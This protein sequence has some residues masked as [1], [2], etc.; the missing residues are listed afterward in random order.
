M[1][2]RAICIALVSCL[3]LAATSSSESLFVLTFPERAEDSAKLV[4]QAT[5]ELM[6]RG[7][8][9]SDDGDSL[10]FGTRPAWV[11]VRSRG[12]NS[13]GLHFI[14]L[15]GGCSNEPGADFAEPLVAEI[16]AS[17]TGEFGLAEIVET[18]AANG[19]PALREAVESHDGTPNK[20][21]E[22]TRGE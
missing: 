8:V 1:T 11:E 5:A 19:R 22:Q 17:M 13:L 7:F 9:R 18:K 20:S 6:R 4:D 3:L 10:Q 16:A 12:R 2:L 21:L 14:A 15:R